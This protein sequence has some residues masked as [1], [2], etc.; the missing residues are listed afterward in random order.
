MN[1]TD[2]ILVTV[3]IGVGFSSPSKI[4]FLSI[5]RLTNMLLIFE[6][7]CVFDVQ[8]ELSVERCDRQKM[9]VVLALVCPD[10]VHFL[11]KFFKKQFIHV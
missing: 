6:N 10:E 5:F 11:R 1:N 4:L 8:F 3:R 9:R 2:Y 7:C